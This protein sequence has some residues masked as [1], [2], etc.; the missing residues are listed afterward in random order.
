MKNF[1]LPLLVLLCLYGTNS[2]FAQLNPED[3]LRDLDLGCNSNNYTILEVFLAGSPTDSSVPVSPCNPGDPVMAYV[4]S[5]YSSNSNSNVSA[6]TIF[7]DLTLNHQDGTTDTIFYQHCVGDLSSSNN[8]VN[9]IMID[10]INWTCGDE[11]IFSNATLGWVTA[12][13]IDCNNVQITDFNKAQCDNVGDILVDAPLVANFITD[14]DCSTDYTANFTS[15]TTGGLVRDPNDP[16]DVLLPNPYQYTWDWGHSGVGTGPIEGPSPFMP[17]DATFSHTFPSAGTYSVTLIVTDGNGTS[18]TIIKNV[19]VYDIITLSETHI[20][21]SCN[22]SNDASIDLTVSGGLAP[23]TYDWDNDGLEDPDND[24]Q[25]LNSLSAGDYTVIVTDAN[26]CTDT[27]TVTINEGDNNPPTAT[28]PNSINVQCSA[29]VPDPDINVVDDETDDSGTPTVAWIS[30][31]SDNNSCPE[32]ITRTYSVTDDCGNSINVTQTITIDD[33]IL[34]TASNPDSVSIQC[35]ADLPVVDIEV[36][37]DEADNCTANPVVAW[38]SDVSDNNSCP[39]VITRTYSVTDDCGNSINVTQTITINDDTLPTASNPDPISIQCS[40]DIP[41]IDIEVVTDEADNCTANPVVAWVSDVSDNNSCPEVITRTYSVTDDCGNSINVTQTITI[42]D[43]ILPTASNPDSVS[44]QCSADLPVVDIEVVTDEA[45]NCTANPVVAW[46]SDVSDNNSCPEVI[47]RTY[48]VTDDCGNSINVIQTITIDDDILPTASNPDS[49]SIQCSADL[50]VVDIEVVTDEADNCTANPVVAWVSDVSDNNSCPE[51]ITRTYSVTDDCGNS[52]NVTQTIT[53]DDD[54]LPT[55]SNPDSVS[56]QCSADLPAVDIEVVTDEADNCTANPV[57]AWVSDVSDNNSCPEVITRTYSVTD[58]CGNSINVTQT[59]IIDDDVLPTA[60]NPDPV[61]IQC[62][63]DIPAVDIEVVTDEADNCTANPVVVWVSDVSDN[64][65]CPEVITRTYSV[66]DDCGNSIN[67]T[68]TITIDDD[69]LPTASNPDPVSIQCSA[70]IPVVDIE[71]VTDEADNCTTNPV[72]AW[73]SD[74]SDNNSCPE[75]ITRTYSVT[76]D[77]GNSINVTQ[78]ITIDDTIAPDISACNLDINTSLDCDASN[79]ETAADQWNAD[80]LATIQACATDNCDIDLTVTSD[81]NFSNLNQVCGPCGTL[82]VTYNVIDDCGNNT[83]ITLNLSFNDNTI[84]DLSN[85]NVTDETIECD[86]T[87]NEAIADQ[88]N[89]DNIAELESCAQDDTAVT[90]NSNYSFTNLNSTCGL[91]GTILVTYTVTDE[92]GGSASLNATLTLN[93]STPPNLDACSV[94]NTT[95]ECD[96]TN[97]EAIADQWNADNIAALESCVADSCDPDFSGQVTSNYAYSNLSSTCGLGGSIAVIYT[98]TDDCGNSSTLNATLT[99]NDSTPPNLDACS[100]TN[101]TIECDGTNNESIADQW[102]ADNIAALESCVA[103]SCDPDFSGQVTSNYAYSNLSSTCGLGGTIEVIYT[104]TD[105]CGNSSTLNATLTLNDSTPPNLDACSVTNTTIECD[106]TNNESIADQWN[107]DNIAALESCVADSCDPDFSGQVTSNYAY[108]NLSST[109]GLG[110][111]IEVIYTITDDCGNSS[112]LNATLTL[113]DSTPPNLDACSVTDTTIE[114]DGTNN[115]AIADQWNADNIAA[116]ESCVADSCDPDFSGQVTSNYAYSNLSSTC[117]LGGTIAVI[118]TITDDCGNLSTLNATLTLNDSTPPNLDACS[119]TNTTIECDGTNNEAIADQWN[120]DNIAALESCVADSCDPDFSGQVTSNY[121]YSNLS[122]TC[123]LGGTIAVI[124]TITDDCG[125]SSTLNAT[126]TL[127]DSTPPNLDACS[128]TDTTIECDGT[129]NESIAD[130]WNADNIAALESCVADSCDPDFSGQVTSNYAYSNLNSTCGLGGTI[131]VIYTITDDCGNSST[132]NATLTLNDST[133]PNLDACSVTNQVLECTDDNQAAADAW[134]AANIAALES[135]VADSCDPDF[136][137]QVI[138]DYDFDN[139]NTT[140]GPC[141]SINVT[142]TITDDCGNS[143]TLSAIL[144]FDDITIPDLS[145]CDVNSLTLEC[146]GTNNESIADQWNADNITA[147]QACA[148]DLGITVTS[149]YSFSN[150]NVSCG[151]AGSIPVTYTVTDD[152]DNS[153]TL[154]VTITFED[155]TAPNLDACSVTDTTIE[156]DGTNNQSIADQWNADNI[157]ALESCVADSCD[158]DFSGQVTSNY[159]YNNLSSTCGLGGTIAVIYTI[160]DDC[161]NS[162]TLNATLTLNDSTPPNLDACSVT[163]TT[164]E[165]DGTNNESI[166][167]QWNADNITALESCVADSCDPD[168]SGQVTSNYAYSNLSSTCGL[169]GTI[170]VI[171]TITDDC[172]NSSTL[173]ATLT[174]N[175]STPPNLDGCSVTNQV[176]E[177][178][179]D[180]QAAADAWNAANIAA[181]EACVADSCDPD[182]SGQVTSDYNFDN[183]NTTCGPCGSINVTYTITDDCGNSSIL[184]AILSFDDITIPDL[185]DCDV[186]SLTLECDGTNN[187]SIADQWNADNIAALQACAND[188]GITVTSDYSFSNLNVSCGL[189]GSIPVTYTVTDDCDNS[190]TLNVTLTFED[191]TAP[192]F[193]ENLPGDIT[194]E[195]DEVPQAETL[196]AGDSCDNDIQISF[197]ESFSGQDDEC[198]NEYTITRTWVATDCASNSF[199]HTQTITVIDSD[200]PEFVASSL[201]QDMTVEC[202]DDIPNLN[203]VVLEAIDNCADVSDITIT[204]SEVISGQDDECANEYTITRTWIATDCAGNSFS[205]TQVITVIDSDAPEFVASSLPQDMTVECDDSIPDLEDVI[206]EVTDNCAEANDITITPFEVISGQDD[207]CANEYTITRSWTA[208]DCA[209]NKTEHI[210][211]ITVIDSTAPDFSGELPQDITLNCHDTIPSLDDVIVTA[212]DNCNSDTNITITASEDVEGQD[213]ECAGAYSIIRTWT[214]T[215][216]AGNSK[217]YQQIITVEDNSAPVIEVDAQDLTVECSDYTE[218]MFEDWLA[219]FGGATATDNCSEVT[220]TNNYT[221]DKW[222]DGCGSQQYIEVTFTAADPCGNTATTSA[223]FSIEDTIAPTILTELESEITVFCTEIPEVPEIEATDNC[224]EDVT[225]EFNEEIV[226]VSGDSDYDIVWSWIVSDECDNISTI[227]QVIH[228]TTNEVITQ[229]I[230]LCIDDEV[231]DL[232]TLINDEYHGTGYFEVTSGQYTIIDHHFDPTIAPVGQYTITYYT[233]DECNLTGTITIIV[234]DECFDCTDD[235]YISKVVTPNGDIY[236]DF[237]K[238]EGL[239]DCG[240][241]TLKIFNRWGNL[242]FESNNY[243][244]KKGG[245]RGNAHAGGSTIGSGTKLPHGTYYYIIEIKN[246]DVDPITGHVFLGTD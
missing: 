10:S 207:E 121:A 59:I 7:A 143:S 194:V 127:N 189:A 139:L 200:A 16:I 237:F 40:A 45:D 157:T 195:C 140:C 51:V 108:S 17:S 204:P 138:S 180:N 135:C 105:D 125:N 155:T 91:G 47:T 44:I 169:G 41:A 137:G 131:A 46:V 223:I 61:S 126:L 152:C 9:E 202:D 153:A 64:N 101:T 148:N 26:G 246:S 175:D 221:E 80:N 24:T 205:H 72:V 96:G 36:V 136:S 56:I 18:D 242:V 1:V 170:A 236:N 87:N 15:T 39:E 231:L 77:C 172:G 81:Y 70:D 178:T 37:T 49:V 29:D 241:P 150:L 218:E 21:I 210:Q 92:C 196:T 117:G 42:D 25:D 161:G 206:L 209:G 111:S 43:D 88:W 168:F 201:P 132:L 100:V 30:D 162:S 2:T 239:D 73:V 76:D 53:I 94:T 130:Q 129:N 212:V 199:S 190:A 177:C 14:V 95:I 35:S 55:A 74:I 89:A 243:D 167:D 187:E 23:Y 220:W 228:V 62:S 234:D 19:T 122:S 171:Y 192:T 84:P 38:V 211:I 11:I 144:S 98:I 123:G 83:P 186:N 149:D 244:S 69:I 182:F 60:S 156:C 107:A 238:V 110:G 52:I 57:V 141:G 166:A 104:I 54:I 173:N 124:Y 114:C 113:N 208:T 4:W 67:V 181:L 193:N 145:D 99:L 20:D 229:N 183:L 163:N 102:N 5:N 146:D 226:T 191:T 154:N 63:A 133:P 75:V 179:D 232:Y 106:G 159:T 33:D 22:A 93:D 213:D 97:N 224:D 12:G 71:V 165:C 6:F 112:T 158:P 85:C 222:I 227:Q 160:T 65:S 116:L 235:M 48:S 120:A 142:Y 216:C 164:I 28:N 103:D 82:S 86:G 185:S 147:L 245:W 214:A 184:S 34:P 119:V 58:D 66:T 109:C 134:N 50:P 233:D 90:V 240:T 225:I 32:V 118:Y 79:N 219:T 128:V 176:L 8:G 203:D 31:V 27:M 217:T 13:G 115:E 188:L 151:Q 174:L 230:E 198:A 68:Q 78:T 3:D 215:D 197:S